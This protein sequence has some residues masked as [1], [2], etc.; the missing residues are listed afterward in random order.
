M[1]TRYV[2]ILVTVLVLSVLMLSSGVLRADE[3]DEDTKAAAEAFSRGVELS[4][5]QK[6]GEALEA[7]ELAAS[8]KKHPLTTYN[9]GV[10]ERA[11][12]RFTRAHLR[13]TEA[14]AEN[15]AAGGSQL[16]Q[17]YRDEAKSFLDQING[18]LV[19]VDVT[20]DPPDAELVIDGRP[21]HWVKEGVGF[22]NISP[23]QRGT[24]VGKNTFEL[25][26]D[27]GA[28]VFTVTKEGFDALVRTEVLKP[29][30]KTPLKLSLTQLPAKLHV[31]ATQSDALVRVQDTEVGPAP[32]QLERPAGEYRV[33]VRKS[34]FVP[35]TTRV[36]LKA[37]Q[38]T[39]LNARLVEDPPFYKRFWFW[40]G[41]GVVAVGAFLTAFVALSTS[42]Y[43]G[44]T[45]GWV[46]QP[47]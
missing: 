9:R 28:H 44:G 6:W 21:I 38:P 33:E 36:L 35:Y 12:G 20:L 11:L 42:E 2:S 43:D 37:G 47:R 13:F 41:V 15:E 14:L 4:K 30:T 3:P 24:P 45:T 16:A 32:V 7:F 29:A 23:P 25:V 5:E 18:L 1:R 27:P 17:S 19:H 22:A 40:S 31:T 34:G 26:V 46:A 8:K 39:E 10:A